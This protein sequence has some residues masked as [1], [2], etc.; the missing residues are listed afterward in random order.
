MIETINR[1][2]KNNDYEDLLI[3]L[4]DE[5]KQLEVRLKYYED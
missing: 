2:K 3:I 4:S 1:E 5:S